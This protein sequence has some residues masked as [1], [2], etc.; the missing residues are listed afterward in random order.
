[1]SS[2][3]SRTYEWGVPVFSYDLAGWNWEFPN[4][5]AKCRMSFRMKFFF[6]RKWTGLENYV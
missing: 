2:K 6:C 4:E 1:L 5:I 3:V